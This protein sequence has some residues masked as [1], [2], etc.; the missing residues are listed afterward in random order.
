ML[1]NRLKRQLLPFF[2]HLPV[3]LIFLP[4]GRTVSLLRLPLPFSRLLPAALAAIP[5]ARL[6]RM[7]TLFAAFEQ[8]PSQ[9]RPASPASPPA[10]R[11]PFAR[12]CKILGRPHGR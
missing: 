12:K 2:T 9:P 6:P 11:L 5:L 8:T 10:S 7:E 4:R 1:R 3:P